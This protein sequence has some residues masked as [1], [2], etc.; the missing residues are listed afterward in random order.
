MFDLADDTLVFEEKRL[1]FRHLRNKD[2]LPVG[3]CSASGHQL[4]ARYILQLSYNEC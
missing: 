3:R 1:R 2:C 4:G